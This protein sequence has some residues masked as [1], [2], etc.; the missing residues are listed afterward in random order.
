MIFDVETKRWF[1]EV[2]EDNHSQL[3]VSIVSLYAREIDEDLVEKK[4]EMV[5]FW[6]DELDKLWPYFQGADRIVGFNSVGFDVPVLAAYADF[7]IERLPHF[8]ILSKVKEVVG[9]RLSL[10][11]I[12]KETLKRQKTERGD[13]AVRLFKTGDGKSLARLKAYCEADVAITRDIYDI[14]LRQG[15]LSYKDKWNTLRV[16]E[17]D[18][19]YPKKETE[20]IGL[21]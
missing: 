19:S 4:G 9:H 21:F 20:Q 13:M 15:K 11:A 18:F 3:G 12:A 7:A 1:D 2:G 5:S 16:V 10:D 14:G 6:E 8:D 17:V